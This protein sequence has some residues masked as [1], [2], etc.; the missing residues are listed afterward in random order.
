MR[1]NHTCPTSTSP[2]ATTTPITMLDLD[3]IRSSTA[4]KQPYRKH[5]C[6]SIGHVALPD[7]VSTIILAPPD[8][9]HVTVTHYLKV[10]TMDLQW[11]W[12]YGPELS[13]FWRMF[14]HWMRWKY[15]KWQLPFQPVMKISPI[16]LVYT[17]VTN[18]RR[19]SP[20]VLSLEQATM[21]VIA[22]CRSNALELS[23]STSTMFDARHQW[24]EARVNMFECWENIDNIK[25]M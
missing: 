6:M 17:S 9:H 8:S 16:S 3:L 1:S 25:S 21:C 5:T 24:W 7:V 22:S 15:L 2:M 19:Q 13:S 23:E 4:S 10:G 14:H 18:C 20:T 12:N 11:L